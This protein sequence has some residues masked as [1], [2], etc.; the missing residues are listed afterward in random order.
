ME[1]PIHAL[2]NMLRAN[3]IGYVRKHGPVRRGQIADALGVGYPAVAKALSVLVQAGVLVTTPSEPKRGQTVLYTV[4][5][6]VVSEMW[7]RLGD[8]IGEL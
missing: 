4:D 1:D 2:G 6:D 3:I 8:A 7:V 5:Q